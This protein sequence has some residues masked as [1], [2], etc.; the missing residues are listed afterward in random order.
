MTDQPIL[1]KLFQI[2]AASV[3]LRDVDGNGVIT[4]SGELAKDLMALK[5]GTSLLVT[6]DHNQELEYLD[7]D[8]YRNNKVKQK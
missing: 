2:N 4:V 3:K 1:T 7:E 8:G 6:I 5:L